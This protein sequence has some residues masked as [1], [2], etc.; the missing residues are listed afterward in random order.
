MNRPL[1][2]V[3]YICG[4]EYLLSYIDLGQRAL[5]FTLKHA[6]KNGKMKKA[7]NPQNKGGLAQDPH[8]DYKNFYQSL[9]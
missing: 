4:R 6:K 7:L 1:A 8:L 5:G 9:I 3:C 2:L